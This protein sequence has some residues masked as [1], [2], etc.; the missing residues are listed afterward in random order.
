MKNVEDLY[1]ASPLQQGL[2]FQSLSATESGAY[3]VQVICELEGSLNIPIFKKA[4][5]R[6]LM[7][8]SI[9]RTFFVW[10][11]MEQVLQVVNREVTLPWHEE[12]WEGMSS[13]E[14]EQRLQKLL[15]QDRM[16]GFNL[17][18]SPLM[19]VAVIRLSNH[20]FK[21][22]WSHHHLLLDGW[23]AFLLIKEV[24]ELYEAFA[25]GHNVPFEA[26]HT[27]RNYIAWLQLQDGQNAE[28][29][30]R[31]RLKGV[32]QP[33]TIP[34]PSLRDATLLQHR[35][36]RQRLYLTQRATSDLKALARRHQMTPN[37]ILQGAWGLV[38]SQYSGNTDVLFG[39]IVSGRP[40]DLPGI[41]T[42]IGPFVNVLPFRVNVRSDALLLPWL[43]ELQSQ[44]SE[45]S[46]YEHTPL[47]QVQEW[48]G[49]ARGTQLFETLM[50]FEN[51]PMDTSFQERETSV[52]IKSMNSVELTDFPLTFVIVPGNQFLLQLN[53]HASYLDADTAKHMLGCVQTVLENILANPERRLSELSLLTDREKEQVVIDWNNTA[54]DYPDD[55]TIPQLFEAQVKTTPDAVAVSFEGVSLTYRELNE[56]ANRVAHYLEE[57]NLESEALIG[58]FMK[59]NINMI[60][61][62][63]GVLKAGCAYVPLDPSYPTERL[64]FMLD[65][66]NLSVVL[67]EE[68][69]FQ[70]LPDFEGQLV[71]VDGP[72]TEKALSS[73]PAVKGTGE[74]LAYVIY[75]SGSTGIPKGISIVH[76]AVTRLVF[77]ST[78]IEIHPADHV[79]QASNASFD[80]ATFEIWGA[81]LH[82]AKLVG[83]NTDVMLSPPQFAAEIRRRGISVMFL[84]TALFNQMVSEAPDAFTTVRCL[85]F[86]GEACDPKRVRELLAGNPPQ[87]LLHVYGPTESTTFASWFEVNEVEPDA[88]TVLIGRP[89]SNT[90]IYLLNEELAIVPV[91]APGEIYIGGDGLARN[92]LHR[93]ALTAER[94]IPNPFSRRPGA[95]L[96]KTGDIARYLADGSVAFIGRADHQVKVRGFRVE[97]GEIEA[98]L[99]AHP[100][101]TDAI[102]IATDEA[103]KE[104]R[105][106]GYVAHGGNIAPASN[107]LRDFLSESLPPYMVPSLIVVMKNLPLTPNGKIDRSALP[108]T[109]TY[110]PEN[111]YQAADD[112]VQ[113]VLVE[114]WAQ[115]LGVE[116]VGIHDNFFELGGDSI[117]G[118]QIAARASRKGLKLAPRQLFE[119]PT[120]AKLVLVAESITSVRPVENATTGEV[121]LTPIQHWFF[122]TNPASSHH[123]NQVVMLRVKR[124]VG[125]EVLRP[126]LQKLLDHHDALRLRFNRVD[127]VWRQSLAN[128]ETVS[129]RIVKLAD[130]SSPEQKAAIER[131]ASQEQGSLN[132]N[133]GPLFR[134]VYFDLGNADEARLLLVIHHLAV[135]GVSW[136]ILL[137]DLQAGCEQ[138]RSSGNIELPAKTT[139]FHRWAEKLQ[140]QAQ[141]EQFSKGV[142]YWT[143]QPWERARPLPVDRVGQATFASLAQVKLSL[144]VEE[145]R[146]LLMD[147]PEVHQTQI[148]EVLLTALARSFATWTGENVLLVDVE[149]HGREEDV[150]QGANLS[151]TVGWF[152]AIYPA[153]LEATAD[154]ALDDAVKRMKEYLRKIPR[155]GIDYSMLRYLSRTEVRERMKQIP[156]PQV[157]FNY[158]G[159]WDQTVSPGGFFSGATEA[160]GL[161]QSGAARLHYLISVNDL[162]ADKSLTSN[163]LYSSRLYD[164][165]TIR[166]L[167]ESYLDSLRQIIALGRSAAVA[168]R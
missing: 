154:E 114:I 111:D 53:Y 162:I 34:K 134:A 68:K 84:T 28:R 133:T 139:S 122:E 2:L 159:Q 92:Y 47:K 7:R 40:A 91:G 148:Q 102:V 55:Q 167:A 163:W 74:S 83:I 99:R 153:L 168:G 113:Q 143:A 63:L 164:A 18:N 151:R 128:S 21:F 157:S 71:S 37:T 46:M 107:E 43:K 15:A 156:T 81:L 49:L 137:E 132:I 140:Q 136:R 17:S 29:F 85:L 130:L 115:V 26:G 161:N 20:E 158:L 106:I 8:H 131:E 64:R 52:R 56:R 142:E 22:I 104:R 19:R 89:L 117:L 138:L 79:A 45:I 27:Y 82:G 72:E 44:H 1:P 127:S 152:T 118:I 141:T 31:E 3:F 90:E 116:K 77:N 135:D 126:V 9:L 12:N 155:R 67:T 70:Q 36:D 125:P 112:P 65:D 101:V 78:Y 75:T 80:A 16:R 76:R 119:H 166:R 13:S 61:A 98:A 146:S 60:V 149:G 144:G 41:E 100:S 57:L 33:T 147:V 97:P 14:Q 93:P 103:G 51:Y 87:R 25:A 123:F 121:A 145:T 96:Y 110:R 11:E 94:F 23:S 30:W 66:A 120:I 5:Q 48:S 105:L 54:R 86:G 10:E 35:T 42:M 88:A 62:L 59:R 38:L 160:T 109:E 50:A 24:F 124:E 39:V 58:V 4:W 129:F 73:D 95:R 32:V 150:V 165:A 69:L 108:T 6:V